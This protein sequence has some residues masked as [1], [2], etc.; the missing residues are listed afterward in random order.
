M[1]WIDFDR[2]FLS[3][4]VKQNR[5]PQLLNF[6]HSERGAKDYMDLIR[7]AQKHHFLALEV[8]GENRSQH[9]RLAFDNAIRAAR[10]GLSETELSAAR[11][12]LPHTLLQPILAAGAAVMKIKGPWKKWAPDVSS[13]P[14]EVIV[15]ANSTLDALAERAD[16]LEKKLAE[17]KK[18]R[19]QK[20][21]KAVCDE[22]AIAALR[23]E[24]SKIT[25]K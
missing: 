5:D 17:R 21:K 1:V 20:G 16:V 9:A 18:A 6:H 2:F 7:E 25:K 3:L 8:S 22:D 15:R 14:R 13:D 12:M 24:L 19:T 11:K 4:A 23:E 10:S